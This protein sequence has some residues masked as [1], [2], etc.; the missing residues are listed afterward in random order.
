MEMGG[1]RTRRRGE[2]R[3]GRCGRGEERPRAG[4]CS[5]WGR[6]HV[7]HVEAWP[8]C[9]QSPPPSHIGLHWHRW[10]GLSESSPEVMLP[11]I[12]PLGCHSVLVWGLP[13]PEVMFSLIGCLG[14]LPSSSHQIM[15]QLVYQSPTC[16]SPASCGWWS[17]HAPPSHD[18]QLF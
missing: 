4:G 7:R 6:P 11:R 8:G 1:S 2:E 9:R 14:F 15:G 5:A 13:F 10:G 16:C 17:R 3:G 18:A 12:G